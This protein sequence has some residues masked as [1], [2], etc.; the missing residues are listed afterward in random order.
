MTTAPTREQRRDGDADIR[1]RTIAGAR[2]REERDLARRHGLAIE[3]P[4]LGEPAPAPQQ[5]ARA[6]HALPLGGGLLDADAAPRARP[7]RAA[8]QPCSVDQL[9]SSASCAIS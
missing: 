8:S 1:V 9:T 5:I 3:R 6:A 4:G 7:R 2:R